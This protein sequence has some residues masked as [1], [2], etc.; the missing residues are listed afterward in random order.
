MDGLESF[1]DSSINLL[2]DGAPPDF[3]IKED[4]DEVA[5]TKIIKSFAEGLGGNM[6]TITVSDPE[7]FKNAQDNP[8]DYNLLRVRMGGW[9]EFFISLFPALQEQH[10]RRPLF[11]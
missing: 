4:F 2:S 1:S 8:D 10:K 11:K 5:L 9:T 7:S 3:N 6:L